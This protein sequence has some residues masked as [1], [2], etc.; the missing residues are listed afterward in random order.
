[1]VHWKRPF[2]IHSSSLHTLL[3]RLEILDH[4]LKGT[5]KVG[6]N[7]SYLVEREGLKTMSPSLLRS[8]QV[9]SAVKGLQRNME[10]GPVRGCN[11]TS[12]LWTSKMSVGMVV[13]SYFRC[14]SSSRFSIQ[15][16][17]S[18]SPHCSIFLGWRHHGST[19]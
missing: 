11:H 17:Y 15:E 12:I 7:Y 14:V 18:K 2:V 4:T 5:R 19:S 16:N 10:R 13:F 8:L 1:M 6:R 3:V 9:T